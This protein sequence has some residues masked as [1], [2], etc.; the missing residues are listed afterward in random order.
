MKQYDW[1]VREAQFPNLERNC[2]RLEG[3]SGYGVKFVGGIRR[4][5]YVCEA[6]A[7]VTKGSWAEHLLTPKIVTLLTTLAFSADVSSDQAEA[8]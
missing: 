8:A 6:G 2:P 4:A 5:S 3:T 1:Q 7:I